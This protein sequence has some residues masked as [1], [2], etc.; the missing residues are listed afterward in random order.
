[1]SNS[2]KQITTVKFLKNLNSKQ[3]VSKFNF[4]TGHIEDIEHLVGRVL[5]ELPQSSHGNMPTSERKNILMNS[6]SDRIQM[7]SAKKVSRT[8]NNTNPAS[9]YVY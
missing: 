7:K 1:M 6:S 2:L 9:F 5:A 8:S 4:E 3:S